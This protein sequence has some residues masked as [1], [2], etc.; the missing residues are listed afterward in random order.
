MASLVLPS[1]SVARPLPRRRA[2]RI[3][4]I[5]HRCRCE[6]RIR[7]RAAT[8]SPRA[9]HNDDDASQVF[10]R[11]ASLVGAALVAS[12]SSSVSAFEVADLPRI[13]HRVFLD[14]GNCPFIVRAD[15]AFGGAGG[16][17]SEPEV[18][19]RIEIGLYGELVPN[20][21]ENFLGLVTASVGSGYAGTVFHR[22]K[23]GQYVLAGKAGS[24]RMGQV[25][26]P[27]FPSNKELLASRS[28]AQRHLRPG[29]VSLALAAAT[30]DGDDQGVGGYTSSNESTQTEFLITTGP[31][32][33]PSLD[34]RNVVFG[35]VVTGLDVVTKVAQ[36]PTFAPSSNS[37]AWNQI[38]EW[39]G[40]DRAAKA[41]TS[42]S[43][44]TIAVVITGCGVLPESS[45][46]GARDS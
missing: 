43:K 5:G 23:P 21:V 29:T 11:R 2:E 1:P 46:G 34:G 35:R 16:L 14:I 30:N 12:T 13:T 9:G 27:R 6:T 42:W 31:G 15:R 25:Q 32:P 4:S 10:T 38:A 7:A 8:E 22:V 28:F 19:G 45:W 41:R 36:T 17:C 18:V 40:D 3:A 37:I 26:A 39:L 33:V 20:V 44:P 24:A